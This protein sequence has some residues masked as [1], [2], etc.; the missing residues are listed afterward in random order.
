VGYTKPIGEIYQTAGI[1]FDFSA[2]YVKELAGFIQE[3]IEQN[4]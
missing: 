2:E 1:K 4:F 3:E